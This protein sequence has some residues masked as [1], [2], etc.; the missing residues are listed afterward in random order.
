MGDTSRTD[1]L[2]YCAGDDSAMDRIY[3]RFKDKLFT[4]CLFV[5]HHQAL[6]ED[7]VQET[8]T[9]LMVQRKGRPEIESLSGWLFVCARNQA[10]NH[11]ANSRQVVPVT[12]IGEVAA[13]STDPDTVRFVSSV[14]ARLDPEERDI[15][16]LREYQQFSIRELA[17]MLDQSEEAVRVRLFRIRKKMQSL[18]RE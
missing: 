10:L 13:T 16:L 4:F 15:I 14:L 1:W 9:R 17:E 12:E 7:I 11:L 18:I 6:S 2:A 3:R 8:F 5:T